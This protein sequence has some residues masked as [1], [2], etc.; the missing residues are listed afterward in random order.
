M[1][2]SRSRS[3][4][5]GVAKPAQAVC[6][7]QVST[8]WCLAPLFPFLVGRRTEHGLSMGHRVTPNQQEQHSLAQIP[9]SQPHARAASPGLPVPALQNVGTARA[10]PFLPPLSFPQSRDDHPLPVPPCQLWRRRTASPRP[11][12]PR[13]DKIPAPRGC[14]APAAGPGER[15][16]GLS[17][18]PCVPALGSRCA[19]TLLGVPVARQVRTGRQRRADCERSGAGRGAG[20]GSGRAPPAPMPPRGEGEGAPGP[21]RVAAQ[22]SL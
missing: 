10:T 15:G 17:P 6:H 7:G 18:G 13:R 20:L 2:M 3:P 21:S 16:A 14:R 11:G 8:S 22:R 9:H 19:H 1:A 12:Q 4:C 5:P